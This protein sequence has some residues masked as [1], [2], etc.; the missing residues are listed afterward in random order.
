MCVLLIL[1]SLVTHIADLQKLTLFILIS[2]NVSSH[3]LLLNVKFLFMKH[4]PF[5][6]VDLVGSST[7]KQSEHD[8]VWKH[9][10]W[11]RHRRITEFYNILGTIPLIDEG[12][13]FQYQATSIVMTLKKKVLDEGRCLYIDNRNYKF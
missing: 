6:R 9:L 11:P 13:K 10:C 8:L 5:G 12:R 2:L 3:F 4:C 7:S 1:L